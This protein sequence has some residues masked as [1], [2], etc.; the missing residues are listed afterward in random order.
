[1]GQRVSA[2]GSL[3]LAVLVLAGCGSSGVTHRAA[4]ARAARPDQTAAQ[5]CAVAARLT[6][7]AVLPGWHMG[8][9]QFLS[10]S[11]GVGI[12]AEDFP[13]FRR[14]EGGTEASSQRQP[15]RLAVTSDAGSA[16]RVTGATLPIG[17]VAG[18]EG[19]EQ[20]VATSPTDVWAVVGRGR[21]VATHDGGSDWQV[22]AIP[23]PVDE[24][25]MENGILWAASCPRVA[26]GGCRPELWR[27]SSLDRSWTR[28]ALPRIVVQS[29]AMPQLAVAAGNQTVTLYEPSARPD[30]ELLISGDGGLHWTR[31]STPTFE[32][33]SCQIVAALTASAPRTLWLLC[34]GGAAAGSSTKGLFRS[35]DTGR[36]WS[37]VSAVT[38]L[39]RRQTR[40]SISLEDPSA[41]A[42]GS[43]TRLWMS[44]ANG[45][46]ESN[47]GGRDWTY[48]RAVDP[49]GWSTAL[50][51]LDANHVWLL[52]AGAGLWRT[53]DGTHWRVIG[54]LNTG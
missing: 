26:R 32:H 18:G 9:V 4:A 21:L 51:V 42:T 22:Q 27:T 6:P 41:L 12:T 47:N 10:A 14:V 33:R 19:V 52:A 48:S 49:E 2:G 1:V 45:L 13:C 30:G 54:P 37:A 11:S 44:L 15:V 50:N 53:T 35:T 8:A 31:R 36:R 34:L 5:R 39:Q 17:P 43:R 28:V 29:L 20:M 40:D 23:G 24:I 46:A 16:W 3:L 25:T 7:G 38:S